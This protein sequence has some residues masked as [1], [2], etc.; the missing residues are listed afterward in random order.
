MSKIQLFHVS[1]EFARRCFPE[2]VNGFIQEV[3]DNLEDGDACA[4]GENWYIDH[5]GN[6][7][8]DDFQF[9]AGF[10]FITCTGPN[11]SKE[12]H[13]DDVQVIYTP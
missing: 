2:Y 9:G 3:K 8:G 4:K 12:H 6:L 13:I 5:E 1:Y 11:E 7:W 10:T